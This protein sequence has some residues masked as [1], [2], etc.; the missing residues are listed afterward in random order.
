M[1][2]FAPG[3]GIAA[4]QNRQAASAS[5]D[6]SSSEKGLLSDGVFNKVLESGLKNDVDVL[7]SKMHDVETSD[8]SLGLGNKKSDIYDIY[9]LTNRVL[10]SASTLKKAEEKAIA[11]NSLDS[12]AIT[13]NNEIYTYTEKG[14]VKKPLSQYKNDGS[15]QALTVNDL[16]YLR[17]ES[18]EFSFKNDVSTIIAETAGLDQIQKYIGDIIESIGTSSTSKEAYQNLQSIIQDKTLKKPTEQELNAIQ[19]IYNIAATS[20]IE[21]ALFKVK[22]S[23]EGK[24]LQQGLQYIVNTLPKRYLNQLRARYVVDLGGDAKDS[25]KYALEFITAALSA[26]NDTK[27]E[28][29]EDFDLSV[30][31]VL[32]TDAGKQAE[33]A[34]KDKM[35]SMT[36]MEMFFNQSLNNVPEGITISNTNFKNRTAITVQGNKIPSLALDSGAATVSKGPLNLLLDSKGQGMG[37]YLDYS[38]SYLGTDKIYSQQLNDV[39][40]DNAEVANVWMPV[41]SEG[42][43]DW[44]SVDAFSKAEEEIKAA[45]ITDIVEKNRIHYKHGSSASYDLNTGKFRK[46]EVEQFLYTTGYTIDD[47]ISDSNSM[48]RELASSEESFV[49]NEIETVYDQLGLEINNQNVWDDIIQVP[50]FIKIK[51]NASINASYYGKQGSLVPKTTIQ[52]DMVTQMINQEPNRQIIG[53]AAGLYQE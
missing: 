49:D 51:D 20:G 34:E 10:Q 7:L 30:N 44:A 38:K 40:Y 14:I 52:Q 8:Y 29:S 45:G 16:I 12:I 3:L 21:T 33:K 53:S 19:Q 6:T 5:S 35:R 39:F 28:Y 46:G 27:Q 50:V 36:T 18:P 43:I 1:A 11:N 32:N 15:E 48:Y 13:S 26:T 17:K 41:D 4:Y 25:H 2:S 24:N 9:A 23:E 42:N 47:T 22:N 31:K 37:K